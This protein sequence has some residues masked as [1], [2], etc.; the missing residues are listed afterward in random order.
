MHPGPAGVHIAMG[1]ITQYAK[2]R[3][4]T[5][6]CPVQKDCH[7]VFDI[8]WM[9][10]TRDEGDYRDFLPPWQELHD[11]MTARFNAQVYRAQSAERP[12]HLA[13]LLCEFEL[14]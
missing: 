8:F 4:L 13:L 5:G 10:V 1:W 3:R 7:G 12:N 2:P 11:R 9:K 6:G 14:S